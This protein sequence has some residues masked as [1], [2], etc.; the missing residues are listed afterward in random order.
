MFPYHHYLLVVDDNAGIRRL[1]F[2]MLT[3]E[4]YNVEIASSGSDALAKVHVRV[5]DLI[6]LDIKMPGLNGLETLTKV[7][8][9]FPFIPVVIMTAYS[10][11]DTVLRSIESGLIRY[12]LRKPFDLDEVRNLVKNILADKGLKE[13]F[14]IPKKLSI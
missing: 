12:F 14:K 2:E 10:E 8:K 4:G 13:D 9:I 3:D 1:L 6:L 7:R 11:L 5:P